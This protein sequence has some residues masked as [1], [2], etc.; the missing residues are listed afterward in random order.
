MAQQNRVG[1]AGMDTQTRSPTRKGLSQPADLQDAVS[2]F[3]ARI[4]RIGRTGAQRGR[5]R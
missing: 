1:A 4:D 5:R 3:A 2:R